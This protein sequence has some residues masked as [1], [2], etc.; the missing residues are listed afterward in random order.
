M[1]LGSSWAGVHYNHC[2]SPSVRPLT[3]S[4]NAYDS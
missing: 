2:A 3:V 1:V 4:E